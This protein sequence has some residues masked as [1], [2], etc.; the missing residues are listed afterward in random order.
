MDKVAEGT[1]IDSPESD[2]NQSFISIDKITQ[3]VALN[4]YM[5]AFPEIN[6]KG[7]TLVKDKDG[8]PQIIYEDEKSISFYNFFTL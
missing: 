7:S 4:E 3:Q 2:P 6:F 8:V 1:A 5:A